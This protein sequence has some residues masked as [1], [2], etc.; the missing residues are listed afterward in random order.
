[1]RS[2]HKTGIYKIKQS[3]RRMVNMTGS[4]GFIFVIWQSNCNLGNGTDFGVLLLVFTLNIIR[5]LALIHVEVKFALLRF[6][7]S[8]NHTPATLL[9]LFR[10]KSRKRRLFV[11][12]RTQ[13]RLWFATNFL[14][15]FG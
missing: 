5:L 2:Q 13:I 8:K 4:R 3:P 10:K 15:L 11:C 12:K 1:M 9:L 14:R 6:F 7:L